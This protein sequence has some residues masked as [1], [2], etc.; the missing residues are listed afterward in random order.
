MPNINIAWRN[1]LVA[2]GS[3]AIVGIAMELGAPAWLHGISRAVSAYDAAALTLVVLFW[4][5][6]MH[7]DPERTQR[8]AAQEDPGRNIVLGIVLVA[9]VAGLASA[10]A[11][12]GHGPQVATR[13][14]KFVGYGLAIGAVVVGWLLIHTMFTFRYAHLY[15]FDDDDDN[16]A[17]RGLTFPGGEDPSDYDF[18]Y[19]SFVVGMTYQVSD[20]QITDR[21][22]RRLVLYH[23]LISFAYATMILAL[24]INIVSGLVH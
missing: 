4:S 17:D 2:F 3:A 6:A 14:E 21:R 8:R 23:A 20:V 1:R 13:S 11:I 19:F 5:V 15:Y 10:I 24:A 7:A 22:V 18:A 16:E 12:L 9:V